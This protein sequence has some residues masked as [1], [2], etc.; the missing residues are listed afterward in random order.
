MAVK[1]DDD[2]TNSDPIWFLFGA[3]TKCFPHLQEM[4]FGFIV[5][6]TVALVVLELRVQQMYCN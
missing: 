6:D 5:E 4:D 2:T 3:R 1:V